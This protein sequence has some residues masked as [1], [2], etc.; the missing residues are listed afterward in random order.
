M[1][2][3][4]VGQ[5]LRGSVSAQFSR[6]SSTSLL[7]V[8]PVSLTQVRSFRRNRKPKLEVILAEDVQGLGYKGEKVGVQRGFA[9]NHLFPARR[10]VY[11]SDANRSK[12]FADG[13]VELDLES[14]DKQREEDKLKGRLQ[15]ISL[16]FRRQ[17]HQEDHQKLYSEV[18]GKLCVVGCRLYLVCWWVRSGKDWKRSMIR[19]VSSLAYPHLSLPLFFFLFFLFCS[20]GFIPLFHAITA[21]NIVQNLFKKYQIEVSEEQVKLPNAPDPIKKVMFCL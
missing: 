16:E 5:C 2:S 9:H 17:R 1:L 21:K 6:V 4:S 20:D 15:R 13:A 10:A 3:R 11:A 19:G 7:K 18:N 14:I 12:I 8:S